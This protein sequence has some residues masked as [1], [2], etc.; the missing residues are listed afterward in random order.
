MRIFVVILLLLFSA[1]CKRKTAG[2][3]K[4]SSSIPLKKPAIRSEIQSWPS[5]W[6]TA[7]GKI[8]VSLAGNNI[9]VNLTLRAEEGKAIWFSASAFGLMEVARGRLDK[10][11]VRILDKFN[12][13]CLRSGMQGLGTYLPV[14][15]GIKQFQHFLMGRV[16]WDSLEAGQRNLLGDTIRVKGSQAGV[17]F[18][19]DLLN[20]FQLLKAFARLGDARINLENKD[21]RQA[22]G[23]PVAFSK[24]LSSVV[25]SEGK[26]QEAKIRI[27]FTRFEFL[28]QAPDL[29]FSLPADCS[30]MELK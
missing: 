30:P 3:E 17:D 26:M 4:E 11:S 29:E 23:F 1:A 21:F 8:F 13:R 20:K 6:W 25:E 24:E 12:N 19:A 15:M 2:P 18:S 22:S 7:K 16:F 9:P 10:D 5:P 14:A 27:E 28:Q